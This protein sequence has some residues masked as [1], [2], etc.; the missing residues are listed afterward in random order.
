M[1]ILDDGR[2]LTHQRMDDSALNA[3][4]YQ[5]WEWWR[6]LGNDALELALWNT[7][8]TTVITDVKMPMDQPDALMK[9]KLLERCALTRLVYHLTNYADFLMP[10]EAITYGARGHRS[11][12]MDTGHSG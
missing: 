6:K 12:F 3:A 11:G 9:K 2:W 1:K 8:W 5:F 4:I 10:R 7:M